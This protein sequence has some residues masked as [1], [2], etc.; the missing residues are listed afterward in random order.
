VALIALLAPAVAACNSTSA[1]SHLPPAA[2]GTLRIVSSLPSKGI[3]RQSTAEA[4]RAIDAA[5]ASLDTKTEVKIEHIALEGGSDET[6]EWTA[7]IEERNAR[8]AAADPSVVAYLG[9]HNSGAAAVALPVTNRAGLLTVSPSA[10]WPGLTQPGWDEG[11]PEKYY[12]AGTRNFV[13]LVPPDSEQASAA[14]EW[15]VA[16]GRG[17]VLVLEDGSTYSAGMGREFA[18]RLPGIASGPEHVATSGESVILPSL[19]GYDAVFVA[20][21]SV[22]SAARLA[23]ALEE[24]SRTVYSTDVALD[25]QFIQSAGSASRNWLIVSNGAAPAARGLDTFFPDTPAAIARSRM[26]LSAYISA[27]LV[28]EAVESGATNRTAVLT[29][30]RGRRLPDDSAVFDS[31][32]DPRTWAMTGY[33]ASAGGF[34]AIREFE[35]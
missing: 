29:Y 9:P 19:E 6:G 4:R 33:M 24:T 11:E 1:P 3:Y 28:V 31:A 23:R 21:S 13:R 35:R 10:T 5:L 15:V 26:A 22:Q 18:S 32:G 12:P 16:D 34:E 8:M 2:A 14:A 20:P 7:G 17:R 30:V 27:R 25:P